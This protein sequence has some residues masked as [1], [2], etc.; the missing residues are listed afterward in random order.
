[1]TAKVVESVED[2]P[3]FLMAANRREIDLEEVL[4]ALVHRNFPAIDPAVNDEAWRDVAFA[5]FVLE[6]AQKTP[7]QTSAALIRNDLRRL[8]AAIAEVEAALREMTPQTRS[9]LLKVL[10]EQRK[11]LGLIS[12]QEKL[13]EATPNKKLWLTATNKFPLN[14]A[15]IGNISRNVWRQFRRTCM[16]AR[17][18]VIGSAL[19]KTKDNRPPDVV[20]LEDFAV[21]LLPVWERCLA[22]GG[23][24]EGKYD[25]FNGSNKAHKA[26]QFIRDVLAVAGLKA[27]PVAIERAARRAAVVHSKDRTDP[28]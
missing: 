15:P 20:G 27:G 16:G 28:G 4:K 13:E 10:S 19:R 11:K 22:A 23:V 25:P 3:S 17:R 21:A 1:M 12:P 18:Y 24:V 6:R 26:H 5:L 7:A 9:I 8:N 14:V 2:P